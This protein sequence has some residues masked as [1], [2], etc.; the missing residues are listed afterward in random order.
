MGGY[1]EHRRLALAVCRVL[2]EGLAPIMGGADGLL[3][4]AQNGVEGG[5][6]APSEPPAEMPSIATISASLHIARMPA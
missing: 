2:E 1:V 6:V 3:A 4:P 5:L